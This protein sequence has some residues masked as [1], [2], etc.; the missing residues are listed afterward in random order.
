[1]WK[2]FLGF[3]GFGHAAAKVPSNTANN[4]IDVQ[5]DNNNIV[6]NIVNITL[7]GGVTLPLTLQRDRWN[8]QP[9]GGGGVAAL[10]EW[11][12]RLAPLI[13]REAELAGLAAWLQNG[14]P[15]SFMLLHADGGYGKTRLAAEFADLH[16][17]C[18]LAES[19]AD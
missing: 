12:T 8:V 7:Q 1:M 6:N 15:L 18:R 9:Q 13:G 5:G 2:K 4:D 14:A 11:R 19:L 3:W 10:L 17:K 16:P